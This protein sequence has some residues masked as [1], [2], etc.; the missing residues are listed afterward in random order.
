MRPTSSMR[1]DNSILND[2]NSFDGNH[3]LS[4]GSNMQHGSVL[5]NNKT[6]NKAIIKKHL[7]LIVCLDPIMIIPIIKATTIL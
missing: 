4:H 2:P 3:F 5:E 6:I 7:P 1:P